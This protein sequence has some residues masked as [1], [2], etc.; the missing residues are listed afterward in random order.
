M[1][2]IVDLSRCPTWVGSEKNLCQ[3]RRILNA[4]TSVAHGAILLVEQRP[5][6]R[7]MEVDIV[8]IWKHKLDQAKR[9]A[10]AGFLTNHVWKGFP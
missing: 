10:A 3:F 8:S 5:S 4:D 1:H 6:R 9:I 7:V 2:R